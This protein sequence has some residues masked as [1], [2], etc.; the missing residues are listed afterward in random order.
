MNP[1]TTSEL[2][3]SLRVSKA[4]LV[5]LSGSLARIQWL[6]NLPGK[7][8]QDLSFSE[9][10]AQDLEQK[11][12][13]YAIDSLSTLSSI[14]SNQPVNYPPVQ[15]QEI[16]SAYLNM[17]G[18]ILL[19]FEEDSVKKPFFKTVYSGKIKDHLFAQL[20]LN[21]MQGMEIALES[22]IQEKIKNSLK[23]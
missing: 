5:R 16:V 3:K 18:T 15:I 9:S 14:F 20:L 8:E 21:T 4:N 11:I 10:V 23:P 2:I 22:L 12:T 19:S 13:A 17:V 1:I 6:E 7:K